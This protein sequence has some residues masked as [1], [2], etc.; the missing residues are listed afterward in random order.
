MGSPL[1]VLTP[2]A[3]LSKQPNER[4]YVYGIFSAVSGRG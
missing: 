3:K 2:L 4:P 1:S